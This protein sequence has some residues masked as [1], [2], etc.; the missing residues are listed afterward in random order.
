MA[1]NDISDV[2]PPV[3]VTSW[4]TVRSP[5]VLVTDKSPLAVHVPVTVTDP[6]DDRVI[7]LD[8]IVFVAI[9]VV[10]PQIISRVPEYERTPLLV[11]VAIAKLL[12]SPVVLM[13]LFTATPADVLV[14]L[15][16]PLASQCPV[17]VTAFGA[18]RVEDPD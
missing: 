11:S 6:M 14:K 10:P 8:V 9:V 7:A 18:I 5:P 2:T 15:N 17:I 12:E 1:T 13:S 16:A 3:V 4:F